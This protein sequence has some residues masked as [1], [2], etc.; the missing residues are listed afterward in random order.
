MNTDPDILCMFI[1]YNN[2]LEEEVKY[3]KDENTLLIKGEETFEC[4]AIYT[5]TLIALK[6]IHNNFDYK[7]VIR[8]NLSSFWCFN[9][10]KEYLSERQHGKYL[11]GWLVQADGIPFL[12]G[13]SIII[14][15]NLVPLIFNHIQTEYCS[16]DIEI[17]QFYRSKDI[18]IM[19]ARRKLY[20]F[21]C[22]FEFNTKEKID[23]HFEKM[24]DQKIVF[25]RVKNTSN[26]E[27]NDK[28]CLDKLLH[29]YY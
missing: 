11:L 29:K 13:T 26:R 14:P 17:S 1:R 2:D 6:Y 19:D 23:T 21:V 5:K 20:N 27:E 15:N 3:L 25:Y 4:Q 16:D 28:Y 18:K 9:T 10:L 22:N 8:T 24:K 12:S 7:Y